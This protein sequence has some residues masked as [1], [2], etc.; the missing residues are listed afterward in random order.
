MLQAGGLLDQEAICRG[1]LPETSA[2]IQFEKLL[3]SFENDMFERRKGHEEPLTLVLELPDGS[4]IPFST[5]RSEMIA[6]AK[7]RAWRIVNARSKAAASVYAWNFAGQALQDPETF[8]TYAI[9]DDAKVRVHRSAFIEET[10]AEQAV[11]ETSDFMSE[12]IQIRYTSTRSILIFC[13][14]SAAILV[15]GRLS[16]GFR[17][18][19]PM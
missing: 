2:I 17:A 18:G 12:R 16:F 5:F 10:Q 7:R 6:K 14:V 19:G 3:E 1:P 4:E 11:I 9:E 8:G 15:T 13:F